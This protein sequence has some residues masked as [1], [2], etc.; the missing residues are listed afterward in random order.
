V[1]TTRTTISRRRDYRDYSI[2]HL[3]DENLA[4]R[5]ENTELRA[6]NAVLREIISVALGQLARSRDQLQRA[7][8]VIVDYIHVRKA[9]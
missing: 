9:A 5:T 1:E 8:R 2:E 3:G 7:K 6:D 4:L